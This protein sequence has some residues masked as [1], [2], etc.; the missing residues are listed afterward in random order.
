VNI[1]ARAAAG[2]M[3]GAF[4]TYNMDVYGA[5]LAVTYRGLT[6]LR[7]DVAS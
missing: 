1:A 2:A 4:A 7:N 6:H 5:V 3:A